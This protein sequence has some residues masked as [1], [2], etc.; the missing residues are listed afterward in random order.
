MVNTECYKTYGL[1]TS[2]SEPFCL[3]TSK[4]SRFTSAL[5]EEDVTDKPALFSVHASPDYKS[6]APLV[7]FASARKLSK[8]CH[9]IEGMQNNSTWE[10]LQDLHSKD[11]LFL[12]CHNL[13]LNLIAHESAT[14]IASLVNDNQKRPQ[15]H[16]TSTVM[17]TVDRVANHGVLAIRNSMSNAPDSCIAIH[18][19]LRAEALTKISPPLVKH[20]LSSGPC[21]LPSLFHPEAIARKPLAKK[22]LL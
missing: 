17:K 6:L 14:F 4:V 18:K 7:A 15:P 12:A 3:T 19:E 5:S 21:M 2:S 20:S 10:V 9:L 11:F 16:E 1:S 22:G 8:D 13:L